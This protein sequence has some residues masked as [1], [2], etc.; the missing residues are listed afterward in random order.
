M[1]KSFNLP[2][3]ILT[4]SQGNPEAIIGLSDGGWID[5]Q[6]EIDGDESSY[7]SVT[8]ECSTKE[9][10]EGLF[11]RTDGVITRNCYD[12]KEEAE[13]GLRKIIKDLKFLG[14]KPLKEAE[15]A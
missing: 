7:F 9:Y 4:S 10:D 12:T 5:I 3:L 13:Q 6:K 8:R 1:D 14:V 2:E 15:K 11:D